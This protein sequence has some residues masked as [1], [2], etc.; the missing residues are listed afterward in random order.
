MSDITGLFGI[1]ICLY[2]C[3]R[4]LQSSTDRSTILWLCFAVATNAIFGSSRQIAWLG[5]LVMVPSALWLLR[6]QR[7]VLIAG[8]AAMLA[9]ALFIFGCMH[10]FLR[11]PYNVH[12]NLIPTTF[13]V[14]HTLVQLFFTVMDVPFLLLPIAALFLPQVRRSR[15]RVTALASLILL[16]YLFLATYPSHLRGNFPLEPG[17]GMVGE[18]VNAVGT[19]ANPILQGTLPVFLGRGLQVLLT[20]V[21]LGGLYGLITSL[22]RSRR[23]ATPIIA[24]AAL[25]WTQLAVL[26]APFSIVYALLLI[27]RAATAGL[28]DRYLLPLLV[29]TLLCLLRYYQDRI[30]QRLPLASVLMVG[31][32]AIYSIG[33]TH[34]MF[35]F[36]RARVV[37]AAEVR[38]A[39]V[40]D[41]AVDNG[42]EYNAWVELQHADYIN[43]SRIAFPAHAYV[44][45]PPLPAG[46]CKMNWHDQAPHIQPRY[47]I[48][49]EPNECY[50]PAPFAPVHYSRWLASMP[51]TLYVVYYTAPPKR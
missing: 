25:S 15:P 17:P 14:A 13:P 22:L 26:L 42:W 45:T 2:G 18:W 31:I 12:E 4:A 44:P 5:M 6:A 40:P 19:F 35:A 48:S 3:L 8:A 47:G 20:I 24:S 28:R 43:D 9:G 41:T 27:P 38:T 34:D 10:W 51:G 23:A 36:Y 30:Q 7:R 29:V 1:V 50:G 37:M 16:G 21:S 46:T 32:M 33:I 49:F 11:Q 39:G